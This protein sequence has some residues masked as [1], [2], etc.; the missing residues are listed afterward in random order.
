MEQVVQP[1]GQLE[2]RGVGVHDQPACV[3]SG[4]P[5]D[6]QKSGKHLGHA[7]TPGSRVDVPEGAPAEQR[8]GAVPGR[9]EPLPELRAEER[10]E[11]FGAGVVERN[12]VQELPAL[13]R[14]SWRAA[15]RL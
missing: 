8:G 2:E 10:P 7:A 1:L 4:A 11:R 5:G 15:R 9:F 3:D 12:R 13:A 14:G 6:G